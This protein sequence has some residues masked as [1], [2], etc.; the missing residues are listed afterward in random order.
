MS[1]ASK[2]TSWLVVAL[3]LAGGY[4]GVSPYIRIAMMR[5]AVLEGDYATFSEYVDYPALRENL[6]NQFKARFVKEVTKGK[7]DLGSGLAFA[8]GP[9]VVDHMVDAYV[10]PEGIT[11]LLEDTD[12][13]EARKGRVEKGETSAYTFPGTVAQG[14]AGGLDRFVVRVERENVNTAMVFRRSGFATWK[15]SEIDLPDDVFK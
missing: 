1:T 6:K 12:A 2:L 15:L 11:A 14:Y 7:S 5:S 10:T 4:Y 9:M 13:D 3:L 8:F